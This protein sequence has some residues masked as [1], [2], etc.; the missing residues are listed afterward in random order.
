MTTNNF[1]PPTDWAR[2]W[3]DE[4]GMRMHCYEDDQ[5]ELIDTDG[6]GLG[7]RSYDD[8]LAQ[9]QGYLDAQMERDSENLIFPLQVPDSAIAALTA[10]AAASGKPPV[11]QAQIDQVIA[12][13]RDFLMT[14]DSSTPP[15]T[16]GFTSRSADD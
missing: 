4:L 3:L 16:V 13:C 8:C 10:D 12:E 9:L 1:R 7:S 11:T 6:I 14:P 2:L 5:Y 15:P